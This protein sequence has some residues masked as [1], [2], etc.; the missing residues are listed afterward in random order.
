MRTVT[1]LHCRDEALHAPNASAAAGREVGTLSSL[2][3]RRLRDDR[4]RVMVVDDEDSIREL[5][6]AWLSDEDFVVAT[7]RNGADALRQLRDFCPDVI[8]LDLM[9]P[10]MDGWAFAEACRRATGAVE[11][12][13]VV[14]SAGH[15][16]VQAA[17]KLRPFGV[18]ACLA[19]P[20]D[21]EV[22]AATANTLAEREPAV[23]AAAS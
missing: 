23:V 20:F 19:K 4:K 10:V 5:T 1:V 3:S 15:G 18:R 7:A 9:M 22:L 13:I 12:P 11:V 16:L 8:V 6:A 2:P 14:V 17:E 21:L